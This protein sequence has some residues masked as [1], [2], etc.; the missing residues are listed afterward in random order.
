[1][2]P[3]EVAGINVENYIEKKKFAYRFHEVLDMAGYENKEA[4]T[5]GDFK[6]KR[7]FHLWIADYI[8]SFL[9]IAESI[10]PNSL[11]ETILSEG[12]AYGW[13]DT[14]RSSQLFRAKKYMEALK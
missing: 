13:T 7:D 5:R 2:S 11:R 12:M 14:E 8:E 3:E 1:M 9:E 6:K 4:K 10:Y